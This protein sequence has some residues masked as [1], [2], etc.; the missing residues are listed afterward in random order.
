MHKF[1]NPTCTAKP[2]VIVGMSGGVD[3]SVAACIL[4][5]Q[6][7]HVEGL[8]MKNWEAD[9]S[10]DYCAAAVDFADAQAVCQQL[11]IPLHH[12]NFAK[13]YWEKVFASFL[14][15]YADCRT[16]NP[17][18]LCNKE[19][20]FKAFFNHA[21]TLGANYIATGHYAQIATIDNNYLLLKA[22]DANK[23]QTYFLHAITKETLAK[24]IFPIGKYYKKEVRNF[25]KQLGLS[26][27]AKKDS[28]GICFIGKK[29]FKNFLQEFI[30]AQPGL[31]KADHGETLGEHEGLM[32]YTLGQRQGLKIGGRKNSNHEPWY[33]VAKDATTNTLI[34][35]QGN[36]HPMLYSKTLKCSTIHWLNTEPNKFP[37][38]CCARIRYRQIDQECIIFRNENLTHHVKF[39][40]PQRAITPG[41]YIVFYLHN[42]CLGGAI[43]D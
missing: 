7:Y 13:E 39:A 12:I 10:L 14:N 24:T 30:L 33:V 32:F 16:P 11:N 41:Q 26:N 42:Q 38:S 6:G 34:V 43:I 19:I 28:T 21:L 1:E 25:A 23:D 5:A 31:I 3:S 17:D 36:N 27:F 9:D 18:I 2:K 37:F 4:C 22:K 40:K 20:K 29:N 35:A 8:F 15:E